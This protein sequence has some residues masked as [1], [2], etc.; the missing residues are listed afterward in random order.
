MYIRA[1]VEDDTPHHYAN[2]THQFVNAEAYDIVQVEHAGEALI[3][4]SLEEIMKE[5]R[6]VKK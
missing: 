5:S 3:L 2:Y 4:K 1:Y 6:R